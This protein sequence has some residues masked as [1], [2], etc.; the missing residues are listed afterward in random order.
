MKDN[1][2]NILLI[3]IFFAAILITLNILPSSLPTNILGICFIIAMCYS[4]VAWSKGIKL[5]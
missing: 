1:N 3:L 2:K 5:I 4:I